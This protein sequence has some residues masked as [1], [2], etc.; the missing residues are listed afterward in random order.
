MYLEDCKTTTSIASPLA[1]SP[2]SKTAS[3]SEKQ[4]RERL[5]SLHLFLCSTSLIRNLTSHTKKSSCMGLSKLS[6]CLASGPISRPI[7]VHSDCI[8]SCIQNVTWPINCVICASLGEMENVILWFPKELTVPHYC[9]LA[10]L[11]EWL[12][13]KAIT[14]LEVRYVT[15]KI[16]GPTH[17]MKTTAIHTASFAWHAKRDRTDFGVLPKLA[18]SLV[19]VGL[20]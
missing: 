5:L 19:D 14:L 7:L 9:H 10:L 11:R 15:I 13:V 6:R 2:V 17:L 18:N 16:G 1:I 8:M 3:T 20:R 4:I 12:L